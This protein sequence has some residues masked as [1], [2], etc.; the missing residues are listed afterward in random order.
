MSL[1]EFKGENIQTVVSVVKGAV[2]ILNNNEVLSSDLLEIIFEIMKISS[3]DNVNTFVTTME[4]N[5]RED[6]KNLT[7]EDLLLRVQTKYNEIRA[8]NK[9]E[10]STTDEN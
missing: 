3:T 1:K 8:N 4:T 10:I 2:S 5:H 9:W 7:I 6:V